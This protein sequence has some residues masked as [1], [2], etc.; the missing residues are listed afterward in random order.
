MEF[1]FRFN[2]QDYISNSAFKYPKIVEFS[3]KHNV[4]CG[5]ILN[6]TEDEI[7]LFMKYLDNPE[8]L[9]KFN[10]NKTENNA[11]ELFSDVTKYNVRKS[12]YY[13]KDIEI[14]TIDGKIYIP[15]LKKI[16]FINKQVKRKI[17]SEISD[18]D[19]IRWL[20]LTQTLYT[21][22]ELEFPPGYL[23]N[24]DIGED[25]NYPYKRRTTDKNVLSLRFENLSNISS[26]KKNK[27]DNEFIIKRMIEN[28]N[29]L[30]S[31]KEKRYN[32]DFISKDNDPIFLY[33]G[34]YQL[35][36][37][38]SDY[39]F[40]YNNITDYFAEEQRIK[41]HRVDQEI[42]S[43]EYWYKNGEKIEQRVLAK[44]FEDDGISYQVSNLFT[45]REVMY[46]L[47]YEISTFKESL[48]CQFIEEYKV[49][50][51]LDISAG[52]G[53]R[54]VGCMAKN[55][56]YLGV[57]PNSKMQPIYYKMINYFTKNFKLT[58]KFEVIEAP[59]EKVELPNEEFEMIFSSPPFFNL[60]LY[61][62][63]T[64]QSY[65]GRNEEQWFN[66]FLIFS[67]KKAWKHLK[68]NG[69]LVLYI[70]DTPKYKYVS[71]MISEIN[72]FIDSSYLG[73]L[74]HFTPFGDTNLKNEVITKAQPFW[75][76]QKINYEP[77][78]VISIINDN[79]DFLI[80]YPKINKELVDKVR[81]IKSQGK[82]VTIIT[83]YKTKIKEELVSCIKMGARV[84][85]IS[86]STDLDDYIKIMNL[87]LL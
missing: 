63:E 60:E 35:T 14:F 48:I 28:E 12:I 64:T 73:C 49:K 43:Y 66:D 39:Y 27:L 31:I 61:S 21:S 7:L 45:L 10:D 37:D 67:I 26:F 76:W 25:L 79:S 46:K 84:R 9:K 2:K 24:R 38:T 62:E 41:I 75:I 36:F 29:Y 58:N 53:N 5:K 83:E 47:H 3:K 34:K 19:D 80:H 65:F 56:R 42:S 23:K 86:Y 54:L 71:R 32:F 74:P 11:R 8:L 55:V 78:E 17:S 52:W 22:N 85:Y 16:E 82:K 51:V 13:K 33:Q 20:E 50:S 59:F 72:S 4:L 18:E 44:K 57:D 30:F 40:L 6:Y 70:N 77:I 81:M 87:T 69:Y 68:I 15:D 1:T